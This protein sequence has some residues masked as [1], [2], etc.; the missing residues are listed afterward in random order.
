MFSEAGAWAVGIKVEDQETW[1]LIKSGE[2]SG[3]SM[4]G[5]AERVPVEKSDR[6]QFSDE[7]RDSLVRPIIE[8]IITFVKSMT[9]QNPKDTEMKPEEMKKM[10][11]E[12]AK[13]AVEESIAP[14][15]KSVEDLKTASDE[16]AATLKKF[17]E[18]LDVLE[19]ASNGSNQPDPKKKVGKE[20]EDLGWFGPIAAAFQN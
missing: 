2:Y 11:A 20:D 10:F 17:E 13:G 6:I 14:V 4:G 5:F 9:T 18:R 15:T 1:K 12:A 19:K 7:E 16:T 3:I 8:G